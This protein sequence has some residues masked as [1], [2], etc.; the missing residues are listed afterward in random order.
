[1]Y[2]Q[3]LPQ[4]LITHFFFQKNRTLKRFIIFQ[5]QDFCSWSLFVWGRKDAVFLQR[6]RPSEKKHPLR[7][8]QDKF[9]AISDEE[10]DTTFS[11]LA[12]EDVLGF[13]AG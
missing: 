3:K 6:P 11:G 5:A 4:K 13:W 7:E 9:K 10:E 2:T 8:G 1:M 12:M